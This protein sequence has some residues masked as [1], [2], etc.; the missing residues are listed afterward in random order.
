MRVVGYSSV[1]ASLTICARY[2]HTYAFLP[3]PPIIIATQRTSVAANTTTIWCR[4]DQVSTAIRHHLAIVRLHPAIR[5]DD[6][7]SPRKCKSC[8]MH[9]SFVDQNLPC[10]LLPA[11]PPVQANHNQTVFVTS[12]SPLAVIRS[13][14]VSS[15]LQSRSLTYTYNS[16]IRR[17]TSHRCF[18][19]RKIYHR[20]HTHV[21]PAHHP[22][23]AG[24]VCWPCS[25]RTPA[26]H[27]RLFI[28][29][30]HRRLHCITNLSSHY[31][32]GS[33]KPARIS[34]RMPAAR[35]L[36]ISARFRLPT[37]HHRSTN[38]LPPTTRIHARVQAL[39]CELYSK[40]FIVAEPSLPFSS[41]SRSLHVVARRRVAVTGT[42][43][44][45]A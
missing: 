32:T 20:H 7:I 24:Q 40:L 30:A 6:V 17:I 44:P 34:Q 31:H 3:A 35:R 1:Q 38:H 39:A 23:P 11:R 26:L 2:I 5:F 27:V 13:S 18:H 15:G 4:L 42:A 12:R 9:R 45:R 25:T 22:H 19:L 14:S 28:R 37:S 16:Q 8:R 36:V 21:D 41:S 33:Q 10:G 29:R 43:P